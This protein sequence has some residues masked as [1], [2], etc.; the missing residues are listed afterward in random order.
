M[1]KAEGKGK[2][3]PK[4]KEAQQANARP[5]VGGINKEARKAQRK[6]LEEQR[7]KARIG[8][9]QG[10]ERYLTA[11]DKGPQRRWVRQY[12]DARR[13]VGE[14]L[15]PA[16]FLVL[17]ATFLPGAASYIAVFGIWGFLLIAVVDA[18]IVGRKIRKILAQKY[19]AEKLE[20][21]LRWY[22]AMRMFQLRSLR[23]PKALTKRGDFPE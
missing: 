17:L 13:S 22:A 20:S 16:M 15:I 10:E 12:V 5:L 3:T 2:P 19:G 7:N 8:M 9:M 6:R 1:D 4:R 14:Y 11:R 23:M 18:V 21:G